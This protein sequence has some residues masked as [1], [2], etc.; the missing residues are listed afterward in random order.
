[1]SH[2]TTPTLVVSPT[3]GHVELLF[4]MW[5]LRSLDSGQEQ[6]WAGAHGTKS[7]LPTLVF[8]CREH[9]SAFLSLPELL[10]EKWR[11]FSSKKATAEH[12]VTFWS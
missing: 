2:A 11:L 5:P 1:M 8:S 3:Q 6:P 7:F 9:S 12:L 4:C 10:W